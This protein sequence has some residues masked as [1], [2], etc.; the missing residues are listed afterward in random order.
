M[1]TDCIKGPCKA[2]PEHI[3]AL[4]ILNHQISC[5]PGSVINVLKSSCWGRAG[6]DTCPGADPARWNPDIPDFLSYHAQIFDRDTNAPSIALWHRELCS[7]KLPEDSG[8]LPF[9]ELLVHYEKPEMD[10]NA[11]E[12]PDPGMEGN[13][14][15]R[16]LQENADIGQV[17]I[18]NF[19]LRI[20]QHCPWLIT[21][22]KITCLL[23]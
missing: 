13:I 2:E 19:R 7:E 16:M 20:I 17:W 8:S 6:S 9:Q 3:H 1:V 5:F 21:Y 14:Y 23:L 18:L 12:Y 22:C 15:S 10:W 4:H 11:L